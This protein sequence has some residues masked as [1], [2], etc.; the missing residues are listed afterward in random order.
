[1]RNYKKISLLSLVILLSLFF[2]F[3]CYTIVHPPLT[4]KEEVVVVKEKDKDS[5]NANENEEYLNNGENSTD[6]DAKYETHIYNYYY[7]PFFDWDFGWNPWWYRHNLYPRYSAYFHVWDYPWDIGFGGFGNW[8]Y[9]YPWYGIYPYSSY[10]GHASYP[11]YAYN[12]N[13]PYYY[14]YGTPKVYK[15]REFG[16]RESYRESYN[17][18]RTV[19]E[20]S[21]VNANSDKNAKSLPKNGE[22]ADSNSGR[23][24]IRDSDK[25]GKSGKSVTRDKP[26]S[27]SPKP[28][29]RSGNSDRGSSRRGSSGSSGSSG[30]SQGNGRTKRFSPQIRIQNIRDFSDFRKEIIDHYGNSYRNNFQTRREY[31]VPNRYSTPRYSEFNYYGKGGYSPS[32]NARSPET[33]PPQNRSGNSSSRRE[34]R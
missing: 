32:P 4:V 20:S 26:S 31:V 22:K 12:F 23:R 13:N 16:E 30:R 33:N 3:S 17:S 27:S 7:D 28:S 29:I 11:Y 5:E 15:K 9:Y 10:Y 21:E 34:K 1:M 2:S 24:V 19:R 14:D 18:K 25:Q 8:G 6:S